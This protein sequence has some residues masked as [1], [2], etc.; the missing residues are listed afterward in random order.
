MAPAADSNATPMPRLPGARPP[1]PAPELTVES[2]DDALRTLARIL[3]DHGDRLGRSHLM[4]MA[5]R[6]YAERARLERGQDVAAYMDRLLQ[7][8]E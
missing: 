7:A 3:R 8:A 5:E 6:L 1:G 2:V 4:Q